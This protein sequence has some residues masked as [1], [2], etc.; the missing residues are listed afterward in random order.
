VS[1]FRSLEGFKRACEKRKSLGERAKIYEENARMAKLSIDK[2]LLR[3]V[4]QEMNRTHEEAVKELEQKL[5][6]ENRTHDEAKRELEEKI[7]D[8][9]RQARRSSEVTSIPRETPSEHTEEAP[10]PI[11]E[12]D[13]SPQEMDET[14]EEISTEVDQSAHAREVQDRVR[15]LLQRSQVSQSEAQLEAPK[16]KKRTLF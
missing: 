13:E 4:L 12:T 15:E 5:R 16:K 3:Q 9:D 6:E 11:Q 10:E 8:L 14:P 1:D 2:Q 7:A